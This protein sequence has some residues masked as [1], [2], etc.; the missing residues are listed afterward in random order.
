[1]KSVI[2]II[3]YWVICDTGSID[4]TEAIT[5][6]FM[7]N[8]PGEYYHHEWVDFSFNRNL[9]LEIA[10]QKADY[11]FIIDA[12]EILV[13]NNLNEFKNLEADYYNI[14]INRNLFSYYR[15]QLIKS[16]TNISY[17]G[18]LHEY[19]QTCGD[20]KDIENSYIQS[21]SNGSRSQDELK[22]QKDA[23]LLENI[24]K[25]DSNNLRYQFYCAQSYRDAGNKEKALNWYLKRIDNGWVEEKFIATLEAGKL[26]EEIDPSRV[27]SMYLKAYN[28]YPIR[29]ESLCYLSAFFR[30]RNEFHKGYFYASIAKNIKYPQKSLFIEEPCYT[31]KPIDEMAV[32]G[33]YLE[34]KILECI[35]FNSDILND[36]SLPDNQI[37][38][39]KNNLRLCK[40]KAL[41]Y[42]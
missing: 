20:Y 14:K 28:D 36:A 32:C 9:S 40:E 27:E 18:V 17:T 11:V 31:W 16:S 2:P 23:E 29:S 21:G 19:L 34:G 41:L 5:R 13:I 10:K 3:D 22:Y 8:I 42:Y 38:R 24:L 37:L 30:K 35:Q 39:I 33:Y 15:P 25:I 1:L 7:K 4:Y 12:D 26:L 6:Q